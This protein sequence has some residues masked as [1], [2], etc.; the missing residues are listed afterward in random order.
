MDIVPALPPPPPRHR[1][2]SRYDFTIRMTLPVTITVAS[3][4]TSSINFP[5]TFNITPTS[6]YTTPY[7]YD[8]IETTRIG[9]QNQ[10]LPNGVLGLI[11]PFGCLILPTIITVHTNTIVFNIN[12][13]V[14][15]HIHISPLPNTTGIVAA[16]DINA[17]THN[18]L[19][20]LP[21]ILTVPIVFVNNTTIVI[22]IWI[23][24]DN[25]YVCSNICKET[26]DYLAFITFAR[27]FR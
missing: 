4:T 27:I 6:I 26:F 24:N 10:S 12:I 17:L 23:N 18:M 13:S 8:P 9:Y 7:F 5:I 1:Y 16:P 20:T 14:S 21:F 25:I 19:V 3:A 22:C 15:G 11:H 2:Q